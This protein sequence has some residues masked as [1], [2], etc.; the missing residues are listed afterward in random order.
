[1]L[2]SIFRYAAKNSLNLEKR[3]LMSFCLRRTTAAAT[4]VCHPQSSDRCLF[5]S[6]QTAN[7]TNSN[8]T[9]HSPWDD[10]YSQLQD[11]VKKHGHARVPTTQNSE[12][13]KLGLWLSRQR[14]LYHQQQHQQRLPQHNTH[15]EDREYEEDD[16]YEYH[17]S[18]DETNRDDDD[19]DHD[20]SS[21]QQTLSQTQIQK[22]EDLGM[23]WHVHGEQWDKHLRTM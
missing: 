3:I 15:D 21:Q 8:I 5:F 14:T 12:N 2:P 22:L 1:M 20:F 9:S 17:S 18:D 11:F 16:D 13:P 6:T 19:Q 23:I 10:M 7:A 4:T